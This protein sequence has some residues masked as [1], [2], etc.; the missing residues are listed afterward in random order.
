MKAVTYVEAAQEK[1]KKVQAEKTAELNKIEKL[2]KE[3]EVKKEEAVKKIQT[4]AEAMDTAA[5]ENAKAEKAKAETML[6][7]YEARLRQIQTGHMVTEK[8]SDV[9]I[10]GL[11]NYQI[12][13]EETFKRRTA[14][15][16]RAIFADLKEYRF[17]KEE[18]ENTINEWTA[19][20]HPNYRVPGQKIYKDKNGVLTER[21]P[22]PVKVHP[23]GF[24]MCELAEALEHFFCEYPAVTEIVSK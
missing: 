16:L 21:S 8:E 6:E 9:T 10:N 11:L 18:A 15:H 14:E 7:M 13:T 17:K 5:Y 20:V 1:I 3:A 19:K 12:S 24:T 2:K 23:E 4:A 22:V